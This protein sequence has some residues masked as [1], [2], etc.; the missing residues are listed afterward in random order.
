MS[1]VF[2]TSISILFNGGALEAFQ[3]SRGIRQGDLL[4][5]YL[6]ILCMEVLGA[7][8]EDKGRERLWNPIKASQNGPAISHLFFAD[9]LMLFTKANRENCVAIKEVLESFCELSG[10]QIGSEKSRIY[11]SPNV[12]QNFQEGCVKFWASNPLPLLES[13]WVF[14]SSIKEL[15]RILVLCWIE[16]KA[17]CQ[18]GNPI[19]YPLQVGF[20]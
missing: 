10:Q 18:V 17:R 15:N 16:W 19:S 3:P 20:C 9:D 1:Y 5:P 7:L 12:D 13:T 8:I 11:F 14:P 4:S 2:T 6:F